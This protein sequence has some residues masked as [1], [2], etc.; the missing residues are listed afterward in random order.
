MTRSKRKLEAP[1]PSSLEN[2]AKRPKLNKGRKSQINDMT[3]QDD[4]NAN[5]NSMIIADKYAS[6]NNDVSQAEPSKKMFEPA[7]IVPIAPIVPVILSMVKIEFKIKE[8][9]WCKI[10]GCSHWPAQILAFPSNKM[11]LV[12]WFND[13][14]QTKVFRTQLFKFLANFDQFAVRFDDVVG[15]KTAGREALIVFGQNLNAKQQF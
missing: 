9:V 1:I 12:Q 4:S 8:I 11:A 2:K 7:Q 3:L 10:K 5:A 15:L 6:S 14:R 13:Y